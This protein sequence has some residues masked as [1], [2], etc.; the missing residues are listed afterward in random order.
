MAC[1]S[2]SDLVLHDWAV[3]YS[4]GNTV[5]SHFSVAFIPRTCKYTISNKLSDTHSYCLALSQLFRVKKGVETEQT[6]DILLPRIGVNG[7]TLF[8]K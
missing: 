2:N 8:I 1:L 7:R 4:V 5:S 6:C 3:I